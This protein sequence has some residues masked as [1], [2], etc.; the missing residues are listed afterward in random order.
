MA[1]STHTLSDAKAAW[2]TRAMLRAMS[3]DYLL[4]E[5]FASD[6]VQVYCDYVAPGHMAGEKVEAVNQLVFAMFSNAH[7]RHWM[8]DY[9]QRLGGQ[10]PSRDRFAKQ[11]AG[12][13]AAAR[14]PLV[15]L[16]LV[17]GTTSGEGYFDLLADVVRALL[18]AMGRAGTV[19]SGTEMSPG[20][21]TEH[22]PGGTEMSPGAFGLA[23]QAAAEIASAVRY[24]GKLR[25]LATTGGTE[26]S[27]GTG[28]EHS[29]GGTE[30]SPGHGTEHSPGGTEMSPGKSNLGQSL[31]AA[32]RRAARFSELLLAAM[33]GTEMSP[34]T[35]TEMSPGVATE[36]S[37]GA[38]HLPEQLVAE[39]KVAARLAATLAASDG[40]EMSPGGGTE[41]SPGGT[42]MSPGKLEFFDTLS[43]A[44]RRAEHIS[45]RLARQANGTEMSPGTATEM[46]PG[47]GRF[48]LTERL[49]DELARAASFSAELLR[50]QGGTEMSPGGGT[51][52]S[53]GGTEMSPGAL[54][55]TQAL[56]RAVLAAQRLSELLGGARQS[57]E[58][59]PGG[60]GTEMT[61]GA[62][63]TEMSPGA[64]MSARLQA[65]I[66][67]AARYAKALSKAQSGGTE[68]SPGGGTEMSPGA[69]VNLARLLAASVRR[70]ML[71]LDETAQGTEMSP[72][73]GTEQSPGGTEMS[74]GALGGGLWGQQLPAH[75]AVA[76]GALVQYAV[77]LRRQ[78]A[79]DVSGLEQR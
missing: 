42:E 5:Q 32:V 39:I 4:R 65:E 22:S 62:T 68:M 36:K 47:T 69:S 55:L 59:S 11:L 48:G 9:A 8:G 41:Q 2:R 19:S 10:A 67:V 6:P 45:L 64:S 43:G 40:T 3:G 15:T 30:M 1:I 63:G 18:V 78:G 35:A 52:Q 7:L 75:V 14:D 53:P 24:A 17:R 66:G 31:V 72:G 74:P 54:R 13:I 58:M 25:R 77:A 34:G 50:E 33:S 12:A 61:P 79:L 46:S 51:E 71:F 38:M 20:T 56:V 76:L 29:P 26:M 70:A 28:T 21:G 49:R 44:L 57:T 73:G 37:P 23:E 16:A 27:P 60:T